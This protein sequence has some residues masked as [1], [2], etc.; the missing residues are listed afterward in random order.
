MTASDK[1]LGVLHQRLAAVMIQMVEPIE[2]P[3]QYDEDGTVIK[4]AWTEYPSASV[5]AAATTF[6]KNNNI[7]AAVE[8]DEKLKALQ[9]RLASR[10]R[11]TDA[12]VKEAIKDFGSR[13]IQ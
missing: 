7:T 9:E 11:V 12:E 8:T 1:I 10:G 4:P 6:L 2:H 13:L 3:A 5:L